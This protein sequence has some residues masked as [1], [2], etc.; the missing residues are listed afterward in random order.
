M[1]KVSPTLIMPALS[2]FEMLDM[3][4]ISVLMFMPGMLVLVLTGI[5]VLLSMLISDPLDALVALMDMDDPDIS[6][7][8]SDAGAVALGRIDIPDILLLIPID[9]SSI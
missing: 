9:P 8:V 4:T 3:W 7:L 6:I 2:Q 1:D 5:L